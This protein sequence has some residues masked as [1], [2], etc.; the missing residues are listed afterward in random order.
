[1]SIYT[2]LVIKEFLKLITTELKLRACRKSNNYTFLVELANIICL[3]LLN[4]LHL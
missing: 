4:L 3:V 1:M 2:N